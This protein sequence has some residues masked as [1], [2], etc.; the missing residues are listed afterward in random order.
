MNI[1]NIKFSDVNSFS[2]SSLRGKRVGDVIHGAMRAERS[3]KD[4]N[5]IR[6]ADAE[7]IPDNN[8]EDFYNEDRRS[9]LGGS[10]RSETKPR[11]RL[12]IAN[13]MSS[14]TCRIPFAFRPYVVGGGLNYLIN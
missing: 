7:S 2:F 4:A 3:R 13:A 8:E 14:L 11:S 6:E 5:E 9:S 10:S 1:R 12:L